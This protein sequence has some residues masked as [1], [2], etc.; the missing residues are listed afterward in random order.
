VIRGGSWNN[1]AENATSAI[2]NNW[3]PDNRNH[4]VGFRL[5]KASQRPIA[6]VDSLAGDRRTVHAMPRSVSCA[7]LTPGRTRPVGRGS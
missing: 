3:N 7:R 4:N 5:A 2:R 6:A 1:S